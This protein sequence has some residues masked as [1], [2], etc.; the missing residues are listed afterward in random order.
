MVQDANRNLV[1]QRLRLK[2]PVRDFPPLASPQ[3]AVSCT[4]CEAHLLR[5]HTW[6]AKG[7]AGGPLSVDPGGGWTWKGTCRLRAFSSS[8]GRS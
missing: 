1:L 2:V 6:W 7:F 8:G 4:T 3:G 5:Y